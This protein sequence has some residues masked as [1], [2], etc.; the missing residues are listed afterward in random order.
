MS[1]A[2]SSDADAVATARACLRARGTGRERIVQVLVDINRELGYVPREAMETVAIETG[3]STAEIYSVASFYSFIATVPRGRHAIRV[4]GTISCEIRGSREVLEA[5]ESELDIGAG[6]STDDGIFYLE[7][8]SC[9]GLCDGAPAMLVDEV[10]HTDL[11]PERAVGIIRELRDREAQ[12]G[13]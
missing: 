7:K 12:G 4:C 11:T 2:R 8:T 10:P 1:G 3:V 6:E 5:I 9:L 13:S